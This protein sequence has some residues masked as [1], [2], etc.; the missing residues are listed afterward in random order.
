M[1]FSAPVESD[2]S[3]DDCPVIGEDADVKKRLAHDQRDVPVRARAFVDPGQVDLCQ[4]TR[5]GADVA[6]RPQPGGRGVA[7]DL[8]RTRPA[9][10]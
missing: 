2:G 3:V 8:S 6:L 7:D 1:L 9:R 4:H 5:E 10:P